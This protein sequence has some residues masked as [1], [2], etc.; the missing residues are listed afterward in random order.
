MELLF[1]IEKKNVKNVWYTN[2]NQRFPSAGNEIYDM[3]V[4]K[5]ELHNQIEIKRPFNQ[6]SHISEPSTQ[7]A[8][9]LM[10]SSLT[11]VSV[12][13]CTMYFIYCSLEI[14]DLQTTKELD[15]LSRRFL[16]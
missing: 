14:Y 13:T 11:T 8:T 1:T 5:R 7:N 2:M 3:D 4:K 9:P 6:E 16:E 10:N 15:R 12:F